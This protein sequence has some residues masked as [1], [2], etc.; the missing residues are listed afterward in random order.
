M[1]LFLII[2][3]KWSVNLIFDWEQQAVPRKSSLLF[4]NAIPDI[5]GSFFSAIRGL[6]LTVSAGI[7]DDSSLPPCFGVEQCVLDILF[8]LS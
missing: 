5:L 8:I 6:T 1:N 7:S 4:Q 3:S 2:Q